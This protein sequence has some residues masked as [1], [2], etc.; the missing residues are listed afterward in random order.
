[1]FKIGDKV[2]VITN[3]KNTLWEKGVVYEIK[4]GKALINYGLNDLPIFDIRR[5][6]KNFE[7]LELI[8]ENKRG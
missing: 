3:P 5:P 1:M 4:E 2:R 7:E 6:W 8:S